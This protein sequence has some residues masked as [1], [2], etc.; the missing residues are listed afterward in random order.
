MELALPEKQAVAQ[1]LKNFTF[2]G[3]QRLKTVFIRVLHW[4]LSP[5]RSS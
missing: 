1:L 4:S 5:A 3:T 2:Y